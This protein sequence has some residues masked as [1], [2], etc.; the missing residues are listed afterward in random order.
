M[1]RKVKRYFFVTAFQDRYKYRFSGVGIICVNMD[2]MI[3]KYLN[4]WGFKVR[5]VQKE[6]TILKN[7]FYFLLISDVGL[8]RL[9]L[10]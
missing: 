4:P 8:T 10:I 7:W 6:I 3:K 1:Q 5:M 2:L 9:R